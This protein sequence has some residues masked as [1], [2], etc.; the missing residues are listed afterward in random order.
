[1]SKRS[2][3]VSVI[4]VGAVLASLPLIGA[5]CLGIGGGA[6]LEGDWT[7]H[8]LNAEIGAAKF[9][10]LTGFVTLTF[11]GQD[12]LPIPYTYT[13]ATSNIN[14]GSLPTWLTDLITV[15]PELAA[16]LNGTVALVNEDTFTVTVP[17]AIPVVYEFRRGQPSGEGEG[18]GE[19]RNDKSKQLC[20]RVWLDCEGL[21]NANYQ[22]GNSYD[23]CLQE[24]STFFEETKQSHYAKMINERI[25]CI[26]NSQKCY[27]LEIDV[28]K[29]GGGNLFE[30]CAPSWAWCNFPDIEKERI[31]EW[32]GVSE[33]A[34]FV[35]NFR[36]SLPASW[37]ILK[38]YKNNC[39]PECSTEQCCIEL[40]KCIEKKG[41]LEAF[42]QDECKCILF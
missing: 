21:R 2:V 5:E 10:T 33:C 13:D 16:G 12:P 42:N 41:A 28:C 27:D 20:G 37:D 9:D 30:G 38:Y 7:M 23:N 35:R 3:Y 8:L 36:C 24:S 29:I 39:E 17:G 6:F 15:P 22:V 4:I 1:M 14:F 19:G 32:C 31:R 18:E 34:Y 26:I 40:S 11:T 25:N